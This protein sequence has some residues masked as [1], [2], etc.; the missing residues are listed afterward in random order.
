MLVGPLPYSA[1]SRPERTST[2]TLEREERD[3]GE[4]TDGGGEWER[5]GE[6]E[7]ERERHVSPHLGPPPPP[8]PPSR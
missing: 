5:A 4:R 2:P 8:P 1:L 3:G 7:R 6:R